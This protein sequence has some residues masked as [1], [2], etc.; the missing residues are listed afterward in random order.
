[1]RQPYADADIGLFKA[2]ALAA[3]LDKIS[4][5][6]TVRPFACSAENVI[7]TDGVIAAY[8]LVID[9]TA[10]GA[11]A[12][13]M[14]DRRRV[15]R[16]LWPPVLSVG[17]GH[18]ARRGLLTVSA[19]GAVGCTWAILRRL[20]IESRMHRSARL[21]DVAEDFFPLEPPQDLFEPEPGCSAPTFRGSAAELAALSGHMLDLGLQLV[22]ESS[23]MAVGVVRLDRVEPNAPGGIE[24]L[25]WPNDTVV[26]DDARGYEV[27][28]SAPALAQIRTE[29]RRIARTRGPT[30]ET[31]GLLLGEVDDACHCVYVDRAEG[32][33]PDSIHRTDEFILGLEGTEETVVA[34]RE[35][36][37]GRTRYVGM[38][39]IHP[40]GEAGPSPKDEAAMQ[41]LVT[42]VRDAPPY[43]L[44]LIAGGEEHAWSTFLDEGGQPDLS[45]SVTIRSPEALSVRPSRPVAPKT[46]T[47]V[48]SSPALARGR[49][50]RRVWRPRTRR[51]WFW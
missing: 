48:G 37:G 15:D 18:R 42:P 7:D 27:R 47:A 23:A 6:T 12:A 22:G 49:R 3:R 40:Y 33:T 9:A 5:Q 51:R 8:D 39:H 41:T 14:E 44:V 43:A 29:A 46:L 13:Y 20:A 25:R 17:V 28:L 36:T 32:P 21:R 31:G 4:P 35:R 30:I 1:M 34:H 11:V 24:V 50:W 16:E 38:W 45:A 2:S 26:R 19:G 10:S